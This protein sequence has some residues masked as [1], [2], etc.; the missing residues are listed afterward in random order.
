[1]TTDAL[2]VDGIYK[3][4]GGVHALKDIS[5]SI[6]QGDL[7]GLIGPNGS[8][9]STFVNCVSGFL[10]PDKGKFYLFDKD[11]TRLGSHAIF[12]LGVS[13]TFQTV[14][15]YGNM[16][17]SQNL[18]VPFLTEPQRQQENMQQR[19]NG[20]LEMFGLSTLKES[21]AKSL[22]LFEQRKLEIATRVVSNPKLLMLD[23]PAGSFS[24]A[25][26]ETLMDFIRSL[27]KKGITILLIE[28]TMKVI[29]N[30]ANRVIVLNEG[31]IIA[32]STPNE[33]LDDAPVIE[34]Y[35]GNVNK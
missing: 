16:T 18:T 7:I 13:R 2:K 10:K 5:F 11:I 19:I 29:F 27:Q 20:M 32:D 31:A 28:H 3:S 22:T 24:E 33:I 21:R 26:V 23:E 35:L 30:L 9:K 4:F 1:M 17:V 14:R 15:V 25:E 8:G 6:K 12:K 34:A